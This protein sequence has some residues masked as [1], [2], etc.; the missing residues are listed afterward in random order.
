MR[1]RMAGVALAASLLTAIPAS[2]AQ[3]A[4][5]TCT[6]LVPH[7]VTCLVRCHVWWVRDFV[8]SGGQDPGYA[9]SNWG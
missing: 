6:P 4:E 5:E 1:K 3:A 8:M 9:C 7:G 2:A